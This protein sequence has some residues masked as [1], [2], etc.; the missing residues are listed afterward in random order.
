M[1][2]ASEAKQAAR[3]SS[4][5]ERH[6]LEGRVDLAIT[7]WEKLLALS[8][9]PEEDLT[10]RAWLGC[11]LHN[12]GD[13]ERA[14]ELL[15]PICFDR[16]AARISPSTVYKI[17]TR[18][19]SVAIERALP[20]TRIEPLMRRIGEL[21][22]GGENH[23]RCH[24]LLAQGRLELARGRRA[25][26]LRL[27]ERAFAVREAKGASLADTP[28]LRRLI[29]G[30]LE[31]GQ[32]TRARELLDLWDQCGDREAFK[33]PHVEAFTALWHLQQGDLELALR[34]ALLARERSGKSEDISGRFDAAQALCR[35]SLRTGFI[36]VCRSEL[37]K[38]LVLR[39]YAAP[40]VRLAIE[41]IAADTHAG[42]AR[43]CAGLPLV[44]LDS[45]EEQSSQGAVDAPSA[46]AAE[47]GLRR[48]EHACRRGA[49]LAK[50]LDA[51]LHSRH[52]R[53]A[54]ARRRR[55]LREL[56]RLLASGT[57]A[58]VAPA[59]A[60]VTGASFATTA[61][62]VPGLSPAPLVVLESDATECRLTLR[63]RGLRSIMSGMKYPGDLRF[64]LQPA[65]GET[66]LRV[67]VWNRRKW[68]H[69]IEI[70][71]AYGRGGPWCTLRVDR[72]PA[73]NW[74]HQLAAAA[75]RYHAE[76]LR[77]SGERAL[78]RGACERAVRDF[79]AARALSADRW[80]Y[81]EACAR[82]RVALGRPEEAFDLCLQALEFDSTGHQVWRSLADILEIQNRL[83]AARHALQQALARTPS[84]DSTAEELTAR[85][86][87]LDLRFEA[88]EARLDLR[89]PSLPLS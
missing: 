34:W 61:S 36:A 58:R 1:A 83:P 12:R 23:P 19:G 14:S 67:D 42:L 72:S 7:T 26:G 9:T 33:R 31:R 59:T 68:W 29:P 75:R 74:L 70:D 6:Y 35:A 87:E 8:L 85:V 54:V 39:R 77:C 41:L 30:A 27:V 4:R 46:L 2:R 43:F 69:S 10:T 28:Y 81:W 88:H 52:R 22:E 64:V 82:G 51:N 38:L 13:L 62:A 18:A 50:A 3:L 63:A 24:Q 45:G 48:A 84:E 56:R 47:I 21:A 86:A 60:S 55:G 20:L 17:A 73:P 65:K 15:D 79:D 49:A 89:Q 44:D 66:P 5:A 32:Q 25:A 80:Q 37:R 11:A 53:R 57:A 40:D 78:A 71:F 76:R 16:K